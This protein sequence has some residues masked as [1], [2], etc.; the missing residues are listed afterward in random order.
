MNQA[1][2]DYEHE[3][4]NYERKARLIERQSPD[5]VAWERIEQ[6]IFVDVNTG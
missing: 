5:V 1:S 6:S 2:N 3:K 4:R